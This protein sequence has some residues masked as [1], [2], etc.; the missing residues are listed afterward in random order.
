VAL[1]AT[2]TFRVS[3]QQNET[4][5]IRQVLQK[6]VSMIN[7][8]EFAKGPRER[9]LEMLRAFYRPDSTFPK[10]DLPIFFGPLSD[11][12]ARGVDQHLDN[13]LLNFDYL[14]GQKFT[15]G[16]RI[17]E[18]QIEVSSALAAVLATTTSGHSSTDGKTNYVT[19][20]RSTVIMNKM[21]NG[22]WR[23]SHEHLEL[24]NTNNA[25]VMTKAQLG[26]AVARLPK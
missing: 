8:A 12:I 2:S 10:N 21:T 15:Y 9:R 4:D 6:Y 24:Y 23:I 14:F 17:D 20:G 11:P 16:M 7:S 1:A 3:G 25:A 26:A 13:T 18:A 19:R 22:E 5:A